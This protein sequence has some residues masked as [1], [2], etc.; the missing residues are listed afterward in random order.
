[1]LKVTLNPL[2]TF[3][4]AL[5]LILSMLALPLL[6][7]DTAMAVSSRDAACQGVSLGGSSCDT[8]NSGESLVATIVKVIKLLTYVAGIVAV[9]MIIVG[10]FKYMT[11]GGDSNKVA[12]A[13]S[14]LIWALIGLIVVALAQFIINF[15]MKLVE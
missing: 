9:V 2:R 1:M 14:T 5:F 10:G 15:V 6:L 11:S 8:V 4:V 13:K 7:N 12:S 3:V